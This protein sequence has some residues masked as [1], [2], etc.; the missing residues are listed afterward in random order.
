VPVLSEQPDAC[1][2]AD[3]CAAASEKCRTTRPP[4]AAPD[5]LD[6]ARQGSLLDRRGQE[7]SLLDHREHLAA[8]WHPVPTIDGEEPR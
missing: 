1:T 6:D 4:L 7:G 5:G 3:R 8:C 2:F